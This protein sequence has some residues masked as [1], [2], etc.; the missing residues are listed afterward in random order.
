M[1]LSDN[2][3]F[4]IAVNEYVREHID[5]SDVVI[6]D[7][8][9]C[10]IQG[11]YRSHHIN[12]NYKKLNI[13]CTVFYDVSIMCGDNVCD[14]AQYTKTFYICKNGKFAEDF[15]KQHI[16]RID[17]DSNFEELNRVLGE[18]II[19]NI[20]TTIFDKCFDAVYQ[21]ETVGG[22]RTDPETEK[23]IQ[24][25]LAANNTG[26]EFKYGNVTRAYSEKTPKQS[27]DEFIKVIVEDFKSIPSV[28]AVNKKITE[29]K[30]LNRVENMI[31]DVK[32]YLEKNVM[33]DLPSK[34]DVDIAMF[35]NSYIK[36]CNRELLDTNMTVDFSIFPDKMEK[37]NISINIT[38]NE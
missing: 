27:D 31:K 37:F 19:K 4:Q 17:P 15:G 23:N 8:P 22:R 11:V 20:K 21:P 3:K 6:L 36:W 33:P 7:I 26:Y 38:Y 2:Q 1:S 34:H 30:K 24:D 5:K 32:E 35:Y 28:N 16:P 14:T 29:S 18:E 9:D 13:Y 10:K 12:Y 25:W